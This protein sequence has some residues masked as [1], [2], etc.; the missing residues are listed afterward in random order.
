[1]HSQIIRRLLSIDAGENILK[2]AWHYTWVYKR[3]KIR[4]NSTEK[5]YNRTV[6]DL[7]SMSHSCLRSTKFIILTL[8]CKNIQFQHDV[9]YYRM[10]TLIDFTLLCCK[11]RNKTVSRNRWYWEKHAMSWSHFLLFLKLSCCAKVFSQN[12][13]PKKVEN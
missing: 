10:V 4:V 13:R 3:K 5:V 2:F 6:E 12:E 7:Y 1:M 11:A 9:K 8:S